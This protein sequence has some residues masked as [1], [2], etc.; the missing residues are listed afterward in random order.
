MAVRPAEGSLLQM[1]E[2][3]QWRPAHRVLSTEGAQRPA[4][5]AAPAPGVILGQKALGLCW[6]W[7]APL[8]H[9]IWVLEGRGW[10]RRKATILCDN[11]SSI[12]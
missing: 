1:S 4:P 8:S 5:M 2:H 11:T 9:S 12:K 3:L 6:A 10:E 7:E